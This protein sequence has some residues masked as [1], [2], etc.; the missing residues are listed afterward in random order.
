MGRADAMIRHLKRTSHVSPGPTRAAVSTA[1][2]AIGL[3]DW[4]GA[5]GSGIRLG[6]E[7]S[8]IEA[9]WRF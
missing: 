5:S 1:A 7:A 2:T 4:S 9:A 3:T 6:I 8:R